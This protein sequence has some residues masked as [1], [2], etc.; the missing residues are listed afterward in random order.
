MCIRPT[1]MKKPPE[2]VTLLAFA[3]H[4]VRRGIFLSSERFKKGS[5]RRRMDCK[6]WASWLSRWH[7]LLEI[8]PPSEPPLCHWVSVGLSLGYE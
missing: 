2:N 5:T 8:L 4:L 7:T 1:V 6:S 3:K